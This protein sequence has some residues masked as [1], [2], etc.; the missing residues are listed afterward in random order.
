MF[1]EALL[2]FCIMIGYV[3]QSYSNF[4]ISDSR[5]WCSV[6]RSS[7]LLE[8]CIIVGYVIQSNTNLFISESRDWC[9]VFRSSL[10]ILYHCRLCNTV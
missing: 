9:C 6:Y 10:G 2:E 4:L 1:S 7:T 3:I 8:F 5:D